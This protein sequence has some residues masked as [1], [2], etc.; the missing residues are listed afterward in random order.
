MEIMQDRMV[1]ER[2]NPISLADMAVGIKW[3]LHR[4]LNNKPRPFDFEESLKN[5]IEFLEEACQGGAII[6][7]EQLQTDFTGTLAPL[8]FTARH[9]NIDTNNLDESEFFYKVVESSIFGEWFI[10]AQS[11]FP[12]MRDMNKKERVAWN[13]MKSEISEIIEI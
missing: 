13:E 3:V 10:F 2:W 4:A 8:T 7:G 9:I 12:E 11:L 6:C 5:G 1:I